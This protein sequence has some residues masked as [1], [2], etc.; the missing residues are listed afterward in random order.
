MKKNGAKYFHLNPLKKQMA[1]SNTIEIGSS[2]V[3][4]IYLFEGQ[5]PNKIHVDP[6]N[7]KLLLVLM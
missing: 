3:L 1:P 5:F 7:T 4:I 2:E 6:I